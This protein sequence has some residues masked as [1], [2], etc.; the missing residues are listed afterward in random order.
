MRHYADESLPSYGIACQRLRNQLGNN[1]TLPREPSSLLEPQRYPMRL[2]CD[3]DLRMCAHNTTEQGR[4][5]PRASDD[6]DAGVAHG[7]AS[8]FT[9]STTGR[10]AFRTN[11]SRILDASSSLLGRNSWDA[12]A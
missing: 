7:L 11:D 12:R 4:S 8:G 9:F 1:E 2:R 6:E 10:L 3:Y 5:R